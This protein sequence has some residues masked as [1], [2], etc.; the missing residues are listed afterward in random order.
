[1]KGWEL[2]H[3]SRATA[4]VSQIRVASRRLI[5]A[6]RNLHRSRAS[7]RPRRGVLARAIWRFSKSSKGITPEQP[8]RPNNVVWTNVKL[9]RGMNV[10]EAR[11]S[12][13]ERGRENKMC[14]HYRAGRLGVWNSSL[15]AFTGEGCLRFSRIIA[16][17]PSQFGDRALRT[18]RSIFPRNPCAVAPR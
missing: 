4:E 15:Q 3:E 6:S 7:F 10:E 9:R 16:R 13:A 12:A 5:V 18:T 14:E 11:E 17:R 8:R 2:V 1:M